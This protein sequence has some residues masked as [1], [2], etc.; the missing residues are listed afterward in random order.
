MEGTQNVSQQANKTIPDAPD[1]H[2][3]RELAFFKSSAVFIVYFLIYLV[4]VV[5]IMK[6]K[7]RSWR[8]SGL[9]N[10]FKNEDG[11]LKDIPVQKVSL[12]LMTLLLDHALHLPLAVLCHP[13]ALHHAHHLGCDPVEPAGADYLAGPRGVPLRDLPAVLLP[14]IQQLVRL[15]VEPH[16]LYQT[17]ALVCYPLSVHLLSRVHVPAIDLHLQWV[18]GY[19]HVGYLYLCH[20]ARLFEVNE[21][22]KWR[23]G[24]VPKNR[25]L[26][27][28]YVPGRSL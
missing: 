28:E 15:W 23:Q 12:V 8:V 6:F 5:S 7:N 21:D 14:R 19:L 11:S 18:D 9:L 17:Y 20:H 26:D 4:S 22:R 25:L 1:I 13:L 24:K 2:L 3:I 16:V 27:Q 10:W